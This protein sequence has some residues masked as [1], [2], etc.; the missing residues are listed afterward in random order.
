MGGNEKTFTTRFDLL[1]NFSRKFDEI[2]KRITSISK[3][4]H[5][6]GLDLKTTNVGQALGN[7][8]KKVN[9]TT[10]TTNSWNNA[11]GRSAGIA[12]KTASATKKIGA[13]GEKSATAMDKMKSKLEGVGSFTDKLRDKFGAITGLLTG[14][15]VAGM[16]W[17]K[18]S[19]SQN[20][21]ASIYRKM[22]RKHLDTKQLDTFVQGAQGL[23]YTTGSQRLNIADS[24]L[25]RTRLR[26]TKAESATESIEKLFSQDSEYL[27]S[28]GISS[29][30]D[31]ADLLTKKNL[32]RGEKQLLADIG[33]KGG[34]A[35]SRIKSAEKQ[36]KGINAEDLVKG[37]PLTALQNRLGEFSKKMGKTMIEPMTMILGYV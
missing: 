23:G 25:S 10:S 15:M 35:S 32:G 26:G 6:I 8:Q 11:M 24:I 18:A 37:D 14:G 36:A 5:V 13:E 27:K 4:S 28:K 3:G 17:L 21:T 16:A 20:I 34:S 9:D 29:S 2:H 30:A 1:D 31:L 19:D 7:I 33:I 12:D 22:D